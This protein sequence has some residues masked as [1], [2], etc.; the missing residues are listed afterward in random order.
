MNLP[1]GENRHVSDF[2]VRGGQ[3]PAS[4]SI[5]NSCQMR[6]AEYSCRI[7][8]CCQQLFVEQAIACFGRNWGNCELPMRFSN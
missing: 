8:S 2:Y 1:K 5:D 6:V 4:L 7:K 3:L